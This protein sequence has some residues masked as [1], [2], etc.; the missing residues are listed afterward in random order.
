MSQFA[1]DN[2]VDELERPAQLLTAL[3]RCDYCGAQA[4]VKQ[5]RHQKKPWMLTLLTVGTHQPYSAPVDY[6]MRYPDSK[7]AAIAYLDDA[8]DAFLSGLE[9]QGVLKDTLVIVTSDESHGIENVRLASAWGFNLMLAPEQAA[10]PP[11]KSGV[12]G[13]VDLT[14]SILDYFGYRVP[15]NLSGR[16][17]FRDYE[18]GREIMSYT[19]GKLR[20]HDGKDTFTECD[21]RQVCR[22]Y[23][24]EG[25]IADEA[26]YLGSYSG[27]KA[28]MIAQRAS[29]LDQSLQGGSLGQEYQFATRDRIR[30]KEK[31]RDDWADNL[32]G[33]Q[34]MELPKNSRTSVQMSIKVLRMDKQGA[35][36]RLKA[37]EFERDVALPI[38]ELPLLKQGKPLK[39]TFAFDNPEARKAF[40]FHLLAE[41]RG[42]IEISDFRVTT[43]PL[44]QAAVAAEA[45]TQVAQKR[46]LHPITTLFGLL[47]RQQDALENEL[48]NPG[49]ERAVLPESTELRLQQYH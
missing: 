19:N 22:R 3:D 40:S 4:Y 10:L 24:S 44:P 29:L 12:Y 16:S 11:I 17:L 31:A 38:P 20:Y 41:G 36:L 37:K 15:Q 26:R 25:F 13:H 7:K 18:S 30:L 28:R 34:Y 35:Q 27:K 32:I 6:L 1:P 47:S 21:F 8:V 46:P 23:Q 9:K 2:T 48:E 39:V 5:L 33:A 45:N 49:N 43:E 14:A 42:V